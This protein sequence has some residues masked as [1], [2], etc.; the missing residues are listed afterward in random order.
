MAKKPTIEKSR[1][2]EPASLPGFLVELMVSSIAAKGLVVRGL[3]KGSTGE[4]PKAAEMFR[5][6]AGKVG[7]KSSAGK[8][9]AKGKAG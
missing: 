3:V 1:Y 4:T 9:K 8:V 5:H 2:S 7:L 6:T